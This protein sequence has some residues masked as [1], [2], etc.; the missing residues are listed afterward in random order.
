MWW[1]D[2][3][4]RAVIKSAWM[5][6]SHVR[7]VVSEELGWPNGL[8]VDI[9]RDRLYWAD[10]MANRIEVS[11]LDGSDRYRLFQWLRVDIQISESFNGFI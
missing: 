6:G 1:T 8:A 4:E 2:W 5:D 9:E 10:A 11:R 7:E 3:G